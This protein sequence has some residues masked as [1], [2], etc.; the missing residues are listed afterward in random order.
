[1]PRKA[2]V[3]NDF[4]IHIRRRDGKTFNEKQARAALMAAY[5]IA[6]AGGDV[7]ASLTEYQIDGIDWRKNR[8]KTYPY[9]GEAL[10]EVLLAMGRMVSFRNDFTAKIMRAGVHSTQ[11]KPGDK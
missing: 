7:N 5:Q 4:T 10:G 9:K 1:M 11:P 6:K 8:A 3:Y 2:P